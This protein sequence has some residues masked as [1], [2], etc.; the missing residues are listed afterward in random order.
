MNELQIKEL[1]ELLKGI[2]QNLYGINVTL[3]DLNKKIQP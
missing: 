2:K 3:Q 1:L